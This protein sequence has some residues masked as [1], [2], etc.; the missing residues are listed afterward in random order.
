MSMRTIYLCGPISGVVRR[1]NFVSE[2]GMSIS[3]VWLQISLTDQVGFIGSLRV[4]SRIYIETGVRT[5]NWV[6]YPFSHPGAQL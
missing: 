4:H 2:V 3:I 5:L 1:G 6:L